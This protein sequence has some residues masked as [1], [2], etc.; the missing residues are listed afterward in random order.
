MSFIPLDYLKWLRETAADPW[1]LGGLSIFFLAIWQLPPA[2]FEGAPSDFIRSNRGYFGVAFTATASII[3]VQMLRLA[4]LLYKRKD[5]E[6]KRRKAITSQ[7]N[8]LS[9]DELYVIAY[10]IGHK[11]RTVVLRFDEPVTRALISKGLLVRGDDL[12]H[13]YGDP[14]QV[15][16]E[17]WDVL[18]SNEAIILEDSRLPR[19]RGQ[20][21]T[22]HVSSLKGSRIYR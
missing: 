22:E 11:V 10:C 15:P 20:T 16:D 12:G 1:F 14:L 21:V 13:L 2:W 8:T 18:V 17:V 9:L 19:D 6:D 7:I 3:S 4:Y 5:Y